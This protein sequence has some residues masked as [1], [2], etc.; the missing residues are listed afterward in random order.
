[1][2]IGLVNKIDNSNKNIQLILTNLGIIITVKI[3]I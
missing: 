3:N 1:M 2:P